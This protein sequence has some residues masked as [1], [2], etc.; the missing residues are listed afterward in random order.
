VIDQ[1]ALY[2]IN[3]FLA[4]NNPEYKQELY[5]TDFRQCFLA[6]MCGRYSQSSK[7]FLIYLGDNKGTMKIYDPAQ[8]II[9]KEF[10]VFPERSLLGQIQKKRTTA[11]GQMILIQDKFNGPYIVMARS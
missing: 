3:P 1:E 2:K 4:S 7:S 6:S 10:E 5:Q 11:I 9:I 8:F